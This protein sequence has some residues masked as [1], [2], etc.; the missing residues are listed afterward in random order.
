MVAIATTAWS[1]TTF[2][3]VGSDFAVVGVRPFCPE[4]PI[5]GQAGPKT[6]PLGLL[7]RLL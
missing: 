2:F 5:L 6:G 3:L 1:V 7:I 4:E